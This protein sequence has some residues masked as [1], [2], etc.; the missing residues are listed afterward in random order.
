MSRFYVID[1]HPTEA[2]LYF[3][4]EYEY[5]FYWDHICGF[6]FDEQNN[7]SILLFVD[8]VWNIRKCTVHAFENNRWYGFWF[9]INQHRP[10]E[11][12]FEF[13]GFKPLNDIS[14]RQ[15]QWI[16]TESG[17]LHVVVKPS[18]HFN[19]HTLPMINQF[20]FYLLSL[21]LNFETTW[22]EPKSNCSS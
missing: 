16:G 20:P 5:A 8:F 7:N 17:H 13:D 19:C 22:I 10:N 15:P 3:I 9:Q 21:V 18:I 11:K 6:F 12:Q 2:I 1:R 4:S 14:Y